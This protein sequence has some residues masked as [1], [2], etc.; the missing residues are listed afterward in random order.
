[1][2]KNDPY[3]PGYFGPN[4]GSSG[5]H[6][7]K[8]HVTK[9]SVYSYRKPGFDAGSILIP[10][11]FMVIHLMTSVVIQLVFIFVLGFRDP[12]VLQGLQIGSSQALS[13]ALMK[14]LYDNFALLASIYSVVQIVIY[15]LFLRSRENKERYYILTR[16]GRPM[17][18]VNSITMILGCMG[19][20]I[21]WMWLL[22]FLASTL[23]NFRDMLQGYDNLSQAISSD[24]LLMLTI[25][26]AILV[27]IA[28]ELLFR[29]IVLAEMRRFM[30]A[31]LAIILNGLIFALFH[32]NLVQGVY[33]FVAGM[34]LAAAYIWSESILIPIVM[35]MVY[36]FVGS[37]V[38]MMIG[39]NA[40]LSNI[41]SIAEIAFFVLAIFAAVYFYRNRRVPYQKP[42][43]ASAAGA[44]SAGAGAS[45]R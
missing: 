21:L 23:P 19:F 26:V 30:P 38:P 4:D 35:H 8:N 17:D 22:N 20:A 32:G 33:A 31:G 25:G 5:I 34:A 37:V 13:E 27:P 36:N 14:L 28:E 39:D 45:S 41:V 2:R 40:T 3:D 18:W 7:D 6:S 43:P 15:A 1:M 29:G 12:K 42:V 16:P 11:V 9:Y 10:V 24:N 44:G